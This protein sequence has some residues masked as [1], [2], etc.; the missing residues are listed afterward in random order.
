MLTTSATERAIT[1]AHD[2]YAN[3]YLVKPVG[4]E[5]SNELM[6]NVCFYWLGNSKSSKT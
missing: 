5:E 4:C 3:S 2:A 6:H 1:H